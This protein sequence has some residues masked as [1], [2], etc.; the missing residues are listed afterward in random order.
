MPS[1][2]ATNEDG[3]A[4]LLLAAG[5]SRRFDAGPKLHAPFGGIPLFV[6]TARRLRPVEAAQRLCVVPDADDRL[7]HMAEAE[8]FRVVLNPAPE[9]GMGSSLAV[10]AGMVEDGLAILV[11]LADMP[12]VS[13]AHLRALVRRRS[14]AGPDA[15]ATTLFEGRRQPP[16][17]FGPNLLRHLRSLDG[18]KGAKP[19]FDRATQVETIESRREEMG[20]VDTAADLA[21]LVE[22]VE[23]RGETS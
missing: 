3:L 14:L 21:R 19:V 13:P 6:A 16:T 23:R 8:G 4:I 7:A 9:R 15:A 17:V 12:L 22:E 20:D 1:D 5:L 2:T 18:D 11:C 10:G